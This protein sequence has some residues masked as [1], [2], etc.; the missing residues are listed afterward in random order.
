MDRILR[1]NEFFVEGGKQDISHVLLHITEPSTPEEMHKGYFFAIAEINQAETKYITRLQE[2]IDQA[3]NDYYELPDVPG[4][5]ALEQVLKK[6]NQEALGLAKANIT[7]SCIVGA[8]RDPE[9]SFTYYGEPHMLLFYKNR[10]GIYQKMD[11]IHSPDD[12]SEGEPT[13][14]FSQIIQGKISPNDFLFAGTPHISEFFSHDRLQKIITTRP[15]VQSTKHIERVL[16]EIKNGFSFGGLLMHIDRPD[17]GP[18]P[19]KKP[20]PMVKGASSK[21]LHSL[22]DRERTTTNTL[23][24]SLFPGLNDRM[25]RLFSSHD[26]TPTE[27]V[28]DQPAEPALRPAEINS[29]HISHRQNQTPPPPNRLK[30]EPTTKKLAT[31]LDFSLDLIKVIGRIIW[32]IIFTAYSLI[33]GLVRNLILIVFVTLNYQKRRQNI[34]EDW[35]RQWRSYRENIR[36]LPLLTK[37]LLVISALVIIAF[38]VGITLVRMKQEEAARQKAFETSIQLIRAKKDSIESA[39]IYK[40]ERAALS[41]LASAKEII[42]TLQC[43]TKEDKAVCTA[44]ARDIEEMTTRINRIVNASAEQLYTWSSDTPLTNLVK[45]GTKLIAFSDTT[46]TLFVFDL[47]TKETRIIPTLANITGYQKASVPKENDYALF[48]YDKKGVVSFNPEDSSVKILDIAYSSPKVSITDITVYNRRLYSLDAENSQIYRH[49]STKNGFGQGKE[50]IKDGTPIKDGEELTIDGDMFVLQRGK[51]VKFTSG[52]SQPFDIPSL[53]Q[54]IG[55]GASI[56]SYTDLRYLYILDSGNK[57]LIILNKD[58]TLKEQLASSVFIRPLGLVVDEA[59]NLAY[60]IDNN[61]LLK[62]TLPQ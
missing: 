20:T 12:E 60:A 14:L 52:V 7:M 40:D 1:L 29:A 22:F 42:A 45:I 23:S 19:I 43:V 9:I 34:V 32:A 62:I 41:E 38:A 47:L 28:D 61:R 5:G 15:A 11:L 24:T 21:S 58:G 53:N 56:W 36:N 33:Y 4:T 16:S 6:M 13:Q 3:E 44:L 31:A 27:S 30:K 54:D 10:E 37:I 51:L 48:L 55:S 35:R 26:D 46:S 8:I 39:L 25:K 18:I 50:W 49:D 17:S 57:R 59:S 2:L